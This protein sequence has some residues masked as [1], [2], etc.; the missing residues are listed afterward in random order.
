[1]SGSTKGQNREQEISGISRALKTLATELNTPVIAVSQLN[2][3]LEA[4]QDKTPNMSDLRESGAIEQDADM[5][6][7]LNRPAKYDIKEIEVENGR[8]IPSEGILVCDIAKQR[9]GSTGDVLLQHNKTVTR[10]WDYSD[11]GF[12]NNDFNE[13]PF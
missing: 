6:M 7:L 12:G 8:N 1:M 9:N 10:I 2:R 4:R 3:A 13:N 5:I 11:N